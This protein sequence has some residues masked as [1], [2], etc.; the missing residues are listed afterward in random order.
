MIR[1]QWSE[2]ADA[3]RTVRDAAPEHDR[4]T[5]D[6][7]VG[8]ITLV[9]RRQSRRFDARMFLRQADVSETVINPDASRRW[10][11]EVRVFWRSWLDVW[12]SIGEA[13]LRL[14]V[15]RKARRSA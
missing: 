7:V 12:K 9:L 10:S 13:H 2:L 15:A 1:R 14:E 3:I 6:R 4:E 8:A 11:E 5:I